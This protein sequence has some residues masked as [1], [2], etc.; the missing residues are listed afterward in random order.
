MAPEV[1]LIYNNPPGQQDREALGESAG[2]A[3]AILVLGD[4]PGSIPF[5]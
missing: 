4:T 3:V 2:A 1:D 5:R